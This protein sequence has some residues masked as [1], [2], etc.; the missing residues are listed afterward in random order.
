MLSNRTLNEFTF[1]YRAT[2][3]RRPAIRRP[4]RPTIGISAAAWPGFGVEFWHPIDFTQHNFQFKDTLTLNRGRT[5]FR[6]GRRAADRPRRR[7]AAPLGAP[8]LH[9][10]S[11]LD[12]VDDEAFSEDRAVDP[13]TGLSTTAYG[14]YITNEWALF[15]QDNWKV[16][17]NLTLNLGLRYDNFG[18]PSKDADSRTTGSSSA[19]AARGRSRSQNARVGTVERLY[20][21]DWN[22][23]APRFGITWDPSS[24]TASS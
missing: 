1:G 22:N 13:A 24:S 5:P 4:S 11:I 15:F 23:F 17:S 8:E 9:F 18:N 3:R 7:D 6:T 21:T 10:Q 2:A 12:F 16:R 14:K 19:R 20:D